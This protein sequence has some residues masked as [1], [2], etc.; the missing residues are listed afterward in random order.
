[1]L[2]ILTKLLLI[3]FMVFWLGFG[4]WLL[5]RF[6]GLFGSHPDDPAETPGARSLNLTQVWSCWFGMLA[7][8]GYFLFT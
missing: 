7:V 2:V 6:E 8:T 3:A 1:M 5:I 4:A